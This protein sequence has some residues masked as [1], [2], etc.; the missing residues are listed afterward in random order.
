[1]ETSIKVE[2][3]AGMVLTWNR[4]GIAVKIWEQ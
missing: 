1:M 2:K 4:M 3:Y